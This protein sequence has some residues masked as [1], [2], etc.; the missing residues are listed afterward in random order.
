MTS[1]E[2]E[3][4]VAAEAAP[5]GGWWDV[6][7]AGR[8]GQ[9][10]VR[11]LTEAGVAVRGPHGR[12]SDGRGARAVILCVPDREI[13]A[14]G[15]V[16]ASGP[17]V[18]HVSASSPLD[19]LAPH[20]RFMMHPLLSI[21]G[22]GAHFVGA[23]CAIDGSSPE[24]LGIA[25]ELAGLL[26]MRARAIPPEL[27]A[28]YHAAASASSNYVTTVLGM[29]EALGA[30]VGLDREALL[31]LVRAAVEQWASSGAALALTGPI[32]RGDETTVERQRAAV[33]EHAPPVLE[34]WDALATATR[35]LAASRNADGG[36]T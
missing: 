36:A 15:A 8:V 35:T 18:G 21:V 17:F 31:P 27:R 22:P 7:G 3:V 30:R 14:A 11:A 13:E 25:G 29:A 26:G 10:L 34:L 20:E 9:A 23:T 5:A 1:P 33:G 16:V 19:V 28:L 2:P 24:A 4:R 6:V 32:A 12:G